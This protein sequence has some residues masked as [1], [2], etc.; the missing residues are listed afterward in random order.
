MVNASMVNGRAPCFLR[1]TFCESFPVLGRFPRFKN[2]V[3]YIRGFEINHKPAETRGR[4]TVAPSIRLCKVNGLFAIN[5]SSKNLCEIASLLESAPGADKR[6]SRSLSQ[7][8]RAVNSR[9]ALHRF[10]P[11][12]GTASTAIVMRPA[13]RLRT[14][15][16]AYG[17]CAWVNSERRQRG[18]G[19]YA[20]RRH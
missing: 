11:C 12:A 1:A 9:A 19:R 7:R 13:A 2:P 4:Q 3:K 18:R 8:Y 14:K 17:T 5:A 10:L 20:S 6:S 16:V 15:S